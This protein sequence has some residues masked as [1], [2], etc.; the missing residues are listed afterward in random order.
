M[1]C[2][3][4][5]E[6]A[7]AGFNDC[8][9]QGGG[10]YNIAAYGGAYGLIIDSNY[11]FPMLAACT[12]KGQSVAPVVYTSGNLP[13]MM[14]GCYLESN[15]STAFDVTRM[16]EIPG[17][18]LVDCVIKLNKPG[19]VL[20]QNRNQ[21]LFMEN[22]YIQGVNYV[23]TGKVKVPKPKKWTLVE[24]YSS[25]SDRSRTLINGVNSQEM[26]L[27]WK[28]TSGE[29][30]LAALQ[31]KHWRTL[32]SFEDADA[33]NIKDFGATGDGENDDTAA[34]L[35]ALKSSR[36]VFFPAGRYK[37]TEPIKLEP[38]TQLFGIR[39]ASLSA[40]SITTANNPDD[41]TFF[42]FINLSGP[43]EWGCGKGRM[44][45]ASAQ[46]KF[47]ENGGGH[48]YSFRGAGRGSNGAL[49]E[50]TRQPIH[51]YTLNVERRTT[52]PQSF[53]KNVKGFRLYY[54]KAEASPVGYA[55]DGGPD[56]GNTPLAIFDSE[57]VKIYCASGNVLT[58]N[59]RPFIDVVNSR[60]VMI[61]QV[62]S[63]K[64]DDFPQIRETLGSETAEI[65]SQFFAAL[66]LRD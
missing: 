65:P 38:D 39:G 11:R 53:I 10:T 40:V 59:Q 55:V 28:T 20:S 47:T 2:S 34:F 36:K 19:T 31:A 15:G 45:F 56:T 37:I 18:S 61:S 13:V 54:F 30:P 41:T 8:P 63:F 6:G 16:P 44:A 64:T 25:C 48:F 32:P 52:N 51:L 60:N 33:A 43:V 42:S 50:G 46:L 3:V 23:Q 4:Q 49:F 66:Y 57:D 29:P 22:V 12:F 24:R 62:K 27:S 14:V 58:R 9:G 21:N 35:K 26:L 7:L 5:A 1:D 17:V